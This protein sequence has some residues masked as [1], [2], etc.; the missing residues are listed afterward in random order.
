VCVCVRACMCVCV[1]VLD[2]VRVFV[3]AS[4]CDA[5]LCREGRDASAKGDSLIRCRCAQSRC[6]WSGQEPSPGADVAGG[7][8]SPGADAA[9]DEPSHG[10]D[11]AGSEP[12]PGA[13]LLFAHTLS[14]VVSSA[15][16]SAEAEAALRDVPALMQTLKNQVRIARAHV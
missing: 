14:A 1:C 6:R 2:C 12:S 8:P 16:D 9:G 15:K 13:G 10:A 7:E 11:V 5:V 4:V 3:R